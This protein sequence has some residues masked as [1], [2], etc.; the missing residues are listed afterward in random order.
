MLSDYHLKITEKD[1]EYTLSANTC[2]DPLEGGRNYRIHLPRDIPECNFWSVLVYDFRTRLIIKN[3]Q[4][5]PSVHSRNKKLVFNQDGSL[6]IWFGTEAPSGMEN[7][8]IQT[9]RG[10]GWYAVLRLYEVRKSWDELTW[11]PGGIELLAG[12][13]EVAY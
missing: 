10:I 11:R 5:W 1:A 2:G 7:N 6:D 4:L 3:K 9:I 8:W 13:D 12:K